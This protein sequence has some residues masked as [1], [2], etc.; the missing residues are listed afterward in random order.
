MGPRD[1]G[2]PRDSS[3]AAGRG[4]ATLHDASG[5]V[6]V[7][8]AVA[9]RDRPGVGPLRGGGHPGDPPAALDPPACGDA[10]WSLSG[11]SPV[12]GGSATAPPAARRAAVRTPTGR[13]PV[14]AL[15]GVAP[16]RRPAGPSAWHV[17]GRTVPEP[18]VGAAR[19]R[20]STHGTPARPLVGGTSDQPPARAGARARRGGPP[21]PPTRTR[22]ASTRR[23]PGPAGPSRRGRHPAL[24]AGRYEW[25][26]F[27]QS[28]RVLV[29][30]AVAT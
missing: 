28:G 27:A 12:R 4:P 1:G 15:T 25:R 6:R 18:P 10:T 11:G 24:R 16:A 22:P 3:V 30:P 19:T 17:T 5:T 7:R 21:R 29:G 13:P 26:A 14:R 2:R 20:S 8:T 9:G 23:G